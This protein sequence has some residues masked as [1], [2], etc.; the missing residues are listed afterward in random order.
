MLNCSAFAF[1]VKQRGFLYKICIKFDLLKI[2][3]SKQ[4]DLK[5]ERESLNIVEK[6]VF[7]CSNPYIYT[8]V[9]QEVYNRDCSPEVDDVEGLLPNILNY[10]NKR[11]RQKVV[12]L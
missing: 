8:T 7:I 6:H 12:L 11:M 3:T 4:L 1:P 2:M 9:V 5:R 10:S